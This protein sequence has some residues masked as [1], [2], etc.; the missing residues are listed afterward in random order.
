MGKGQVDIRNGSEVASKPPSPAATG[1]APGKWPEAIRGRT[2]VTMIMQKEGASVGHKGRIFVPLPSV[3]L[4]LAPF[5]FLLGQ[6]RL[7]LRSRARAH[8]N[9][10]RVLSGRRWRDVVKVDFVCRVFSVGKGQL[11][12]HRLGFGYSVR[13]EFRGR[14][15]DGLDARLAAEP[16]LCG[17]VAQGLASI[18]RCWRRIVDVARIAIVG[19]VV[20]VATDRTIGHR[21]IVEIGQ[22]L[23]ATIVLGLVLNAAAVA[24]DFP[25]SCARGGGGHCVCGRVRLGDE[26]AGRWTGAGRCDDVGAPRSCVGGGGYRASVSWGLSL[27]RSKKSKWLR[28]EPSCGAESTDGEDRQAA[29]RGRERAKPMQPARSGNR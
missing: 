22:S 16:G 1:T 13:G 10:G 18:W 6:P 14:T 17:A 7:L 9:R 2:S 29:R 4:V 15:L 27:S 12:E 3:L 28:P 25:P 23:E 20:F 21:V 26:S 24:D 19:G 11:A 8:N 5:Y